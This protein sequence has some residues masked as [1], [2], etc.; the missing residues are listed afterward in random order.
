M[1]TSGLLP[2]D[3]RSTNGVSLILL[4]TE[5]LNFYARPFLSSPTKGMDNVTEGDQSF[6]KI[7]YAIVQAIAGFED[8]QSL[9]K[10]PSTTFDPASVIAEIEKEL[11]ENRSRTADANTTGRH[12][13]REEEAPTRERRSRLDALFADNSRTAK[14]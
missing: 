10:R 3:D 12:R 1:A 8:D 9:A 7:P 4:T 11:L 14:A 6:I 2:K 5:P 13:D